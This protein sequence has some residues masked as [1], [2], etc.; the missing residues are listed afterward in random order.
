M[1]TIVILLT[2]IVASIFNMTDN[3]VDNSQNC[4]A[5]LSVKKNRNFESA[6]EDG[7]SFILVLKNTSSKTATY[8]LST[9]NLLEPCD[10]ENST[11]KNSRRNNVNLNVS[12]Q[13]NSLSR[14]IPN[15][16]ITLKAGETYNFVVKVTVPKGTPY[17]SWSCID[18]E[19]QSK[20]CT[21][22]PAKTTLSVF[23]PDPSEG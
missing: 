15:N 5:E 22:G 14:G 6:V 8:S 10:N 23:V 2:T 13:S 4:S 19:A 11:T 7:A 16:E 21:S 9:T 1:K 20:N 12:I 18:V 17:N 3:A